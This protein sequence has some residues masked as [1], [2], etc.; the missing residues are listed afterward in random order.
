VSFYKEMEVFDLRQCS[1]LVFR[2]PVFRA[3]LLDFLKNC[4]L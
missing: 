1:T 2:F 3:F 4:W